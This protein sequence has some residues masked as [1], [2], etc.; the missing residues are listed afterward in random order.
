MLLHDF[1]GNGRARSGNKIAIVCDTR[2]LSYTELDRAANRI[3]W[4]LIGT[5]VRKGDRVLIF[6]RDR[7]EAV[8]SIFGTLR[9]GAVFTVV[10]DTARMQYFQHLLRATEPAAVIISPDL[11]PMVEV[12][13]DTTP[14]PL[15]LTRRTPVLR[16]KCPVSLEDFDLHADD[17]PPVRIIDLDLASLIFT[18]GTK[19]VP[20]GIMLTHRNMVSAAHSIVEYI[21]NRED[22]ILL[23]VLPL[24]FDYGLYQVLMTFLFGGTVVV[25]PSFAFPVRILKLL[26]S[27]HITGFPVLPT[28]CA[29]MEKL[30]MF[31]EGIFPD[32][33]YVTNTGAALPLTSIR[34]LRRSFPNARI[35]SMY[36]LSECKR[37]SYLPP[38]E[39]ETRPLSVGL[40]MPNCEV[41]LVDKKGRR[42][43]D[44]STGE[45]V[46]RGSNVAPGYW[47]MPGETARTFPPGPLPGE[48][49]LR[50]G[51][52]FR[53]DND[54]YLYFVGRRDDMLKCMGQKVSP[55][56]IEDA[57][58]RIPGVLEAVAVGYP[59][60][61][62]GHAIRLYL[63]FSE[64]EEKSHEAI[65]QFLRIHLEDFKIPKMLDICSDLPRN[66]S[67]KAD[68][69]LLTATAERMPGRPSPWTLFETEHT[70][71]GGALA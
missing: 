20:K 71:T 12:S 53:T 62:M 21:G 66:S 8:E 37:V 46:V 10:S 19:G 9:A 16:E 67:C 48:R 23:N 59:D 30:R 29:L 28:I 13:G 61:V 40:A 27:E 25:E 47:R 35:F 3:A 69:L 5:G 60:E 1:L 32:V 58:Y 49:I 33:R 36:G 6:T 50:S 39:I 65:R 4:G 38:E 42:L 2:R 14:P 43:P 18:S 68:R 24:S 63:V 45:L 52:I 41:W 51:D 11:L 64:G 15:I 34:A 7:A 70:E 31:R 54:G 26:E 22:D 55:R 44:G 57:A 56:E 17:P